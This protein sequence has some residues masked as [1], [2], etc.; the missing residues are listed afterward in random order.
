MVV[1]ETTVALARSCQISILHLFFILEREI[2]NFD[3]QVFEIKKY[4]NSG[5]EI[6]NA[7]FVNT[8]I[9]NF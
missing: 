8:E 9:N 1:L 7:I 3:L 4:N 6:N 5:H 2:N